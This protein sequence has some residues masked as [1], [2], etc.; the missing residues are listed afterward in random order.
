MENT[1]IIANAAEQ[2][3]FEKV[4]RVLTECAID[5][6]AASL[7]HQEGVKYDPTNEEHNTCKRL[8]LE[9]RIADT[10]I[11]IDII[12]EFIDRKDVRA[13]V[14]DRMVRLSVQSQ[15]GQLP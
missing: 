11:A 10:L 4:N 5:L 13:A 12:C 1:E 14:R 3:G 6:A 8:D 7:Q 9:G 15:L 2:Y